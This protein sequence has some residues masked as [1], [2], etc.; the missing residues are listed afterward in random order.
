MSLLLKSELTQREYKTIYTASGAGKP[1]YEV[2]SFPIETW[3]RSYALRNKGDHK[4]PSPYGRSSLHLRINEMKYEKPATYWDNGII[5]TASSGSLPDMRDTGVM[6]PFRNL[7][8]IRCRNEYLKGTCDVKAL[9]NLRDGTDTNFGQELVEVKETATWL[10]GY[11]GDLAGLIML[12]YR[13]QIPKAWKKFKKIKLANH[14]VDLDKVPKKAASRWLEYRYAVTPLVNTI[15]SLQADLQKMEEVAAPLTISAKGKMKTKISNSYGFT[16]NGVGHTK[17]VCSISHPETKSLAR[18]GLGPWDAFAAGWELV[19]YSFVLDW[20]F[21]VGSWLSALG[22]HRGLQFLGGYHSQKCDGDYHAVNEVTSGTSKYT[23]TTNAGLFAFE[24]QVYYGF[25]SPT[26][27]EIK[28]PFA[29]SNN[30]ISAIA[31]VTQL[32]YK[33]PKVWYAD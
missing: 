21:D 3:K 26:T 25:P 18:L 4:Q 11:I 31:L 15:D 24:R 10:A 9:N 12:I 22:A 29:D 1:G 28:N 17:L 19:P 14:V 32:W 13:G 33:Q 16:G 8:E 5:Q 20:M 2:S 7:D 27:I 6:A 23:Y 30:L